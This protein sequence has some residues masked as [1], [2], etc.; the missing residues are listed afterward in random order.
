LGWFEIDRDFD[1]LDDFRRRV[2]RIFEDM[3]RQ[4]APTGRSTRWP[5]ANLWDEGETL[6]LEL[7]VPGVMLEDLEIN[8]HDDTLSISGVRKVTAPEG[9][10][11]HRQERSGLRFA[12]SI[13][14]PVKVDMDKTEAT[15]DDGILTVRLPKAPELKPR[16]I[17]VRVG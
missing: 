15:L 10:A 14:L 8:A 17:Q 9:Y 3:A 1:A 13:K 11:V 2:D 16:S 5:R 7:G 12:R 4:P 6:T